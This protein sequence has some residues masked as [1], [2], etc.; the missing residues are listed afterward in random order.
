M[1]Y[2]TIIASLNARID[3]VRSRIRETFGNSQ[4]QIL[5]LILKLNIMSE[6]DIFGGG[7]PDCHAVAKPREMFIHV[8]QL[9]RQHE[10][11]STGCG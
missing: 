4:R 5:T 10:E 3:L 8:P 11:L 9:G 1:E 7:S 2:R 6:I